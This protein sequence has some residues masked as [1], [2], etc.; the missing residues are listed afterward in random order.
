VLRENYTVA[1][2][3][4]PGNDDCGAMSSWAVLSMMGIYSVDPASLAYELVGPTFPKVVIHLHEPYAGK[5]FTIEA[6]RAAAEAPYIQSVHMNNQPHHQNWIS[7]RSIA[8]GGTLHVVVGP[9]PNQRWGAAPEDAPPSLSD[10][11]P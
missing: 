11:K 5:T 1:P 8:T 4:I 3:G 2:D 10:E 9:R 7:F 6:D